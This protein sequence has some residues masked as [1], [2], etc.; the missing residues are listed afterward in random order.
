[1]HDTWS[2]KNQTDEGILTI[3]QWNGTR[4]SSS[5]CREIRTPIISIETSLESELIHKV[6]IFIALNQSI[7]SPLDF[8]VKMLMG[9]LFAVREQLVH[10]TQ[11]PN[12]LVLNTFQ[13]SIAA[14]GDLFFGCKPVTSKDERIKDTFWMTI[15]VCF[16]F[17][18]VFNPIRRFKEHCNQQDLQRW[19]RK[20][21]SRDHGM[22]RTA[23]EEE[24]GHTAWSST[25][26]TFRILPSS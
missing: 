19:I 14:T 24:C 2:G 26:I 12:Y 18:V 22:K 13:Q 16:I 6:T 8:F 20:D 9:P 11:S 23:K 10:P 15:F 3:V 4:E 7:P 25:T 5:E 21:M 1:M 17:V